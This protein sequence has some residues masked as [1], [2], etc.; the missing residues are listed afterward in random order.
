MDVDELLSFAH[1][2][3]N[4]LLVQFLFPAISPKLSKENIDAHQVGKKGFINS[5]SAATALADD[6]ALTLRAKY[7]T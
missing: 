2:H 5:Y 4:Q 6:T 7:V 3:Y 1:R